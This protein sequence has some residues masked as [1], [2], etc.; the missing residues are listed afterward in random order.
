[1]EEKEI[2]VKLSKTG[3]DKF[4]QVL[5][6]A[7]QIGTLIALFIALHF[8][9]KAINTSKEMLKEQNNYNKFIIQ[10]QRPFVEAKGGSIFIENK[11]IYILK[12]NFQN[13]GERSTKSFKIKFSLL[14]KD[15]LITDSLYCFANQLAKGADFNFFVCIPRIR[16]SEDMYYKI[17]LFYGDAYGSGTAKDTIYKQ[18]IY[19]EFPKEF[20]LLLESSCEKSTSPHMANEN[21]R[22]FIDCYVK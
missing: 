1:M 18:S 16:C 14:K 2:K 5:M 8:D 20:Q 10:N 3:W 22:K 17:S 6:L 13:I 21:E 11:D 7:I 9:N 4:I 15:K 19:Y 12:M